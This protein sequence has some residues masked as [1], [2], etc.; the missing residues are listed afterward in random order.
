[1]N[2]SVL[3]PADLY[4]S[5]FVVADLTSAMAELGPQ[6]GVTWRAGGGEVRLTTPEGHRV[7]TTAYALSNEGPHHI[8]LVEAR[9]D[10]LYMEPPS[11]TGGPAGDSWRP[12]HLGWWVDEVVAA[13]AALEAQGLPMAA[14]L[15]MDDDTIP[16][17]CAYHRVSE[18]YYVEVVNRRMRRVLFGR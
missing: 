8:E 14:M 17:M 2:E 10:T 13:S 12:H 4:H 15:G 6:L 11:G 16:P 1:M 5:G 18:G 3:R 9:P 7:V